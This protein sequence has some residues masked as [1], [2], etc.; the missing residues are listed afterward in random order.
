MCL[1]QHPDPVDVS[2]IGHLIEE[3][4]VESVSERRRKTLCDYFSVCEISKVFFQMVVVA[5]VTALGNRAAVTALMDRAAAV[6]T[7]RDR[8]AVI[9][10]RDRADTT[11]EEKVELGF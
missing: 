7:L 6:T 2:F 9:A 1:Q 4:S 8:A 5:N 11:S 10:L 3:V